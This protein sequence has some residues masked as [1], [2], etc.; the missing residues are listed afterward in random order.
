MSLWFRYTIDESK[1]FIEWFTSKEHC[2]S[3]LTFV[4]GISLTCLF[5]ILFTQQLVSLLRKGPYKY[6]RDLKGLV[7][8]KK[9][10]NEVLLKVH[11]VLYKMEKILE[12][13][14]EMTDIK[15]ISKALKDFYAL[16]FE[17]ETIRLGFL[18]NGIDDNYI[19]DSLANTLENCTEMFTS[20]VLTN[21]TKANDKKGIQIPFLFCSAKGNDSKRIFETKIREIRSLIHKADEKF[22]TF[23]PSLYK[24]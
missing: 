19:F 21:F 9:C 16:Y 15:E 23:L 24:K 18:R 17:F 1:P 6:W 11:S 14:L 22:Q 13:N 20:C 10:S 7:K 2:I 4:C 5:L 3:L 8:N 12:H